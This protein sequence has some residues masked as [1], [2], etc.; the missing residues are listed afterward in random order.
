MNKSDAIRIFGSGAELARSIGVTRGRVSQLPEKLEQRDIDRI[1]GA[2][3][4]LGLEKK[5][6]GI[7]AG[8][9]KAA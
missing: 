7:T 9:G 8:R 1:M 3:L 2:A 5:L 6:K 4:R